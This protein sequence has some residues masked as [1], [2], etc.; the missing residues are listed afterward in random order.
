MLNS[1][2][3]ILHSRGILLKKLDAELG[4]RRTRSFLSVLLLSITGIKEDSFAT[5]VAAFNVDLMKT[6]RVCA[7]L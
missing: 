6:L 1:T 7:C 4:K 3:K 2:R 5:Y